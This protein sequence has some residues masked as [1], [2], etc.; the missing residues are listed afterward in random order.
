MGQ[1]DPRTYISL[2]LLL[3]LA[4]HVGVYAFS[5]EKQWSRDRSL[6]WRAGLLG[7]IGT[8]LPMTAI[9]SSL[10]YSPAASPRCC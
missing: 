3:A 4:C 10:Q 7:V 1:Y 9:V 5:R 6:W 8:A 2:R